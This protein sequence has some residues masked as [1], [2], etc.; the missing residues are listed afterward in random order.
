MASNT[1]AQINIEKTRK[2]PLTMSRCVSV[3]AVIGW[4][5][6]MRPLSTAASP[7]DITDVCELKASVRIKCIAI[8]HAEVAHTG[9][10]SNP[11]YSF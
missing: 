11:R 3:I 2:S 7:A 4:L 6:L 10:D 9:G 5:F 1:V 8:P